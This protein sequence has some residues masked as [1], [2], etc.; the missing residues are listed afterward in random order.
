MLIIIDAVF[1]PVLIVF[2]EMVQFACGYDAAALLALVDHV[3]L[4]AG[5]MTHF[6]PLLKTVLSQ[7]S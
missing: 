6:N 2:P 4:A 1:A 5:F 3:T 7:T